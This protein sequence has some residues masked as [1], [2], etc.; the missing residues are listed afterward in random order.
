MKNLMLFE[1]E[2]F[3]DLNL[4]RLIIMAVERVLKRSKELDFHSKIMEKADCS[5]Q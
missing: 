2:L 5:S 1:G 3:K 4:E